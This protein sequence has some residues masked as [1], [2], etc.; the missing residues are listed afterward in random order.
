MQSRCHAMHHD[1][2]ACQWCRAHRAP[3]A[4]SLLR[5]SPSTARSRSKGTFSRRDKGISEVWALR[6]SRPSL[7]VFLA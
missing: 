3:A 7:L 6:A 2:H 1:S 4:V 5:V